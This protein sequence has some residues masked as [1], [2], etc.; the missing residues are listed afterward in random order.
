MR[1]HKSLSPEE[2]R[3]LKEEKKK[4]FRG[5]KKREK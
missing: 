4:K 5:K 1:L 2:Y 3:R